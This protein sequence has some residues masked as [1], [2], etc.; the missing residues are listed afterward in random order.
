MGQKVQLNKENKAVLLFNK[1]ER[2][3]VDRSVSIVSMFSA[4][5]HGKFSGYN[6]Y[7]KGADKHFFYKDNNV[8][9]LDKVKNIDIEKDDV[10]VDGV[11]GVNVK[12]CV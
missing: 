4:Y 12:C 3:W 1:K 9:F 6:I 10:Y 7:F 11:I 8:Q 2:K 5:Y